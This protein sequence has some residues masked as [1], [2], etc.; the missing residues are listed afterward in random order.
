MMHNSAQFVLGTPELLLLIATFL[1]GK[2]FRDWDNAFE[3]LAA[4]HEH[5]LLEKPEVVPSVADVERAIDANRL[6][7]L[8]ILVERYNVPCHTTS[9]V[10][11]AA[12]EGNVA[13][14]QYMLG[15]RAATV[16]YDGVCDSIVYGAA[17]GHLEIVE[18]LAP[19]VSPRTLRKALAYA[20]DFGHVNV[21]A[22]LEATL[23]NWHEAID[24]ATCPTRD[25]YSVHSIYV[26]AP[27][28]ANS[29]RPSRLQRMHTRLCHY[30]C[31]AL[32]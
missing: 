28:S 10:K 25:L 23:L 14:L 19:R 16:H 11:A 5:M 32:A 24:E 6:D 12:A 8:Q 3:M 2:A 22:H 1:P 13:M 30:L 7:V 4:G 31:P 27:H 21:V 20:A 9:L 26:P 15:R 18:E 17:A 29:G